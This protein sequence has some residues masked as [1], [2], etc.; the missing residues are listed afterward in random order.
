MLNINKTILLD[1]QIII[2][3]QVAATVRGEIRDIDNNGFVTQTIVNQELFDANKIEC[4]K[5]MQE[6]QELVWKMED[7]EKASEK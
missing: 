5:Q 2:D 1:G 4:R 6:F 7:E 3:G